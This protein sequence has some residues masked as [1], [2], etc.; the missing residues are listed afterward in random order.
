VSALAAGEPA[1]RRPARL[2]VPTPMQPQAAHSVTVHLSRSWLDRP[3][4]QHDLEIPPAYTDDVGLDRAWLHRGPLL[5]I[6]GTEPV[7]AVAPGSGPRRRAP[8]LPAVGQVQVRQAG[9]ARQLAQPGVGQ[10]PAGRQLQVPQRAQRAAVGQPRV[11]HRLVA[12][13]P[14]A[15]RAS[16]APAPVGAG[17]SRSGLRVQPTAAGRSSASYPIGEHL[18]SGGQ[19]GGAHPHGGAA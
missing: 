14:A 9:Q 15:P 18:S 17:G 3:P 2:P 11:G 16:L 7:S 10:A 1:A 13:R 4:P 5:Q 6:P 8:R 19:T 12:L